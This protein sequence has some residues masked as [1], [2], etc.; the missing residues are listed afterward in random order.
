MH[1]KDTKTRNG[2]G[3]CERSV[4][5]ATVEEGLDMGRVGVDGLETDRLGEE[6]WSSFKV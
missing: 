3:R 6:R 2:E 4:A 1:A 5:K